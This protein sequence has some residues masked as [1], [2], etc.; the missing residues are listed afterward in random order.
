MNW[1]KR[2]AIN[3]AIRHILNGVTAEDVVKVHDRED[4]K[5]VEI[6]GELWSVE[7]SKEFSQNASYVKQSR[8]HKE[9]KK[10]LILKANEMTAKKSES[11]EGVFMG[12]ALLLFVDEY[13]RI[14]S[15]LEQ[16]KSE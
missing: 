13:D 5:R 16:L 11:W 15:E 10:A 4:G 3:W 7:E 6:G 2:K 14:L 12:K 9:I 1:L 8:I